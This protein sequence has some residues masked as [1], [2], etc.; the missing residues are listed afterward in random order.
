MIKF[1]C[2]VLVYKILN[3]PAPAYI[4]RLFTTRPVLYHTRYTLNSP[5]FVSEVRNYVLTQKTTT[6][7]T[8]S[9]SYYGPF[10]F[11]KLQISTQNSPSLCLRNLAVLILKNVNI[12]AH[13]FTYTLTDNTCIHILVVFIFAQIH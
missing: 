10:W 11:N 3:G 4:N 6:T 1:Q 7:K 5:L 13:Y 9:F 2:R 8:R 12:I